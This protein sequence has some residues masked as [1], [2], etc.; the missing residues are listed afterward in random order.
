MDNISNMTEKAD[1]NPCGFR[2]ISS[3]SISSAKPI[4]VT[5]WDAGNTMTVPVSQNPALPSPP[6]N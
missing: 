5:D 1:L 6:N 3:I 4:K 2:E